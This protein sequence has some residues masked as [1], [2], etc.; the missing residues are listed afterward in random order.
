MSSIMRW[1]NDEM[2]GGDVTMALLLLRS[3]AACLVTQHTQI[4]VTTHHRGRAVAQELPRERF[5]QSFGPSR[6]VERGIEC[7]S[8]E[9]RRCKVELIDTTRADGLP[10]VYELP[11]DTPA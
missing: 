3:E 6:S 11:L 9:L 1:R 10:R 7:Q 2:V 4:D 8:L 5:R